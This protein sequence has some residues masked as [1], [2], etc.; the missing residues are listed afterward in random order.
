MYITT[1][2]FN[3]ICAATGR[4]I[5]KGE[6]IAYDRANKKVY[7]E[8]S[9]EYKKTRSDRERDNDDTAELVQAQE[10]AYFDNWYQR[11]Y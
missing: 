8:F 1:A 7:S 2:K 10:D 11:N 6:T 4:R 5:K 9:E 3:S